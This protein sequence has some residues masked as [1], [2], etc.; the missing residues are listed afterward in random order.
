MGLFL[1]NDMAK[2]TKKPENQDDSKQESKAKKLN[3]KDIAKGALVGSIRDVSVDFFHH[4]EKFSVDIRI[5]QL[6][7]K[8][9]EPLFHRLNKGEDVVAE[10]LSQ[11]LVDENGDTYL[12]KDQVDDYFTQSL[13][14]SVFYIVTGMEVAVKNKEGKLN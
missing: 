2:L 14:S 8:I 4:G 12:T 1:E 9:T 11:V 3:F 5:K 13:A 6:P 10:W 7:Y